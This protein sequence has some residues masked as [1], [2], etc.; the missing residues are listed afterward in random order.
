MPLIQDH[1][2]KLVQHFSGLLFVYLES[3]RIKK[4]P[5]YMNNFE[6][7]GFSWTKNPFLPEKESP[8][9]GNTCDPHGKTTFPGSLTHEK[10]NTTFAWLTGKDMDTWKI[11]R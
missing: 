2:Y 9:Q 7:H 5:G 4:R 11:S 6:S 1:R 3:S 8:G 10:K